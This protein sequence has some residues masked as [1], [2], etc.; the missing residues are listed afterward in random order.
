MIILMEFLNKS[1]LSAYLAFVK[2]NKLEEVAR[3]SLHLS[4]ELKIPLLELFKDLPDEVIIPRSMKSMS[5]FA[6]Q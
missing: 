3:E 1:N 5:D 2:K 4:R 6:D